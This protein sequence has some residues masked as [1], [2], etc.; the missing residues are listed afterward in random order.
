VEKVVKKIDHQLLVLERKRVRKPK[1]RRVKKVIDPKYIY[2]IESFLKNISEEEPA[3]AAATA[4]VESQGPPPPKPG[5]EDWVYVQ[6][7]IDPV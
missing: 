7:S 5:S 4:P 3:P 6:E 2:S 1:T